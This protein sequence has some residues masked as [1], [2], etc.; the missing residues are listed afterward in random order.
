MTQ[1]GAGGHAR[2]FICETCGVQHAPSLD[3]PGRCAICEDERQYV[4]S[5]GQRWTTV[6][7]LRDRHR[8][9]LREE[10]PG[11][12]GIGMTPSF[13]IGQRALLIQSPAGNILWD[14]TSLLDDEI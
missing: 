14:C 5:D 12:H 8:A 1:I 10:E 3:P 11:L 7:Q 13:A 9:D 2:A 6:E 4:G